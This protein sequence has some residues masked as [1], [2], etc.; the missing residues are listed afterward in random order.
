MRAAAGIAH[1]PIAV[2]PNVR[3]RIKIV[4][5][6]HGVPYLERGEVPPKQHGIDSDAQ[7]VD[8]RRAFVCILL[9]RLAPLALAKGI[10]DKSHH[11][12]S[13]RQHGEALVVWR[14]LAAAGM[15]AY[16]YGRMIG[17]TESRIIRQ[18]QIGRHKRPWTAL[19][20]HL[21]DSVAATPQD[22]RHLGV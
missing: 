15:S 19:E 5:R 17:R 11:A 12:V 22:T 20:K 8:D 2:M 18:I 14:M 7:V 13:C 10:N 16:L 9:W 4:E 21:L 6:P 1:R 3:T